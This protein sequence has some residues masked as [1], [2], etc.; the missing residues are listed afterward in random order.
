L[1]GLNKLYYLKLDIENI[2]KEIESIPTISSPQITGMP[3]GTNVS[4]PIES[5]F[6]KKEQ[7]LEKL[8]QKIEKYTEELIRIEGIID[9]IDDIEVKAIARMRFIQNMK[10]EDIG[11]QV[12]LERTT[13]SKK[14]R[15]YIDS[16]DI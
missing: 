14:L 1:R 12:H 3:H 5:Y 13:C 7:L 10:W 4:N 6:L 15:K 2:K 8:N 16:M 9:T 11:E